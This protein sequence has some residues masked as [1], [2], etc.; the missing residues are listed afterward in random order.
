MKILALSDSHYKFHP[1]SPEDHENA[2]LLV[3][4]LHQARGKYDLIALVGD[5]FDLWFDGRYT[6]VKQYFPLLKALADLHESGAR[7]I[8][9][10]GNHD[11]W[12]GDFLTSYLGMEI[13]PDVVTISAEG[14]KIRFEHG[15]TRTV[16][17][18]RYQLYRK[19]VRLS[20][21]KHIFSLLHP[22]F[23]LSL[24]TLFS[25]S[26]RSRKENPAL[27]AAKTKGLVSYAQS[28]IRKGKA[29]I[30]VMGHSHIPQVEQ[31]GDGYY[32]NCGD[33]ISHHSYIEI[34]EGIPSLFEYNKQNVVIQE[35]K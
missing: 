21:V 17:D 4:F 6:I 19:V 32:A 1:H 26:S 2:R 13:Y 14:R 28:L 5:I 12:F 34:N 10:S 3:S 31:L 29:D 30:V 27:R 8:F 25:R 18:L 24:G 11:F 35:T 22:D 20:A 33:W 15:D 16:N 23:A 7:L 9:I